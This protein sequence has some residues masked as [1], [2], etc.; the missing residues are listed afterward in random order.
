MKRCIDCDGVI[1][2]GSRCGRCRMRREQQLSYLRTL[3]YRARNAGEAHVTR[4]LALLGRD[5]HACGVCGR[6]LG[7]NPK[8]AYKVQDGRT[9]LGN[10]RLVHEACLER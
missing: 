8:L 1:L 3:H 4:V 5:G 10:L 7:D 6:E 9:H 2:K